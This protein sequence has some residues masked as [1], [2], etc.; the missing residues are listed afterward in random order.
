MSAITFFYFHGT[1][2]VNMLP[3][4]LSYGVHILILFFLLLDDIKINCL[5][6][7]KYI[8]WTFAGEMFPELINSVEMLGGKY[9]VLYVSDP[10][11]PIQLPYHQELERF[12]AEGAG[13][14]ASLNS[15]H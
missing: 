14:N 4:L 3:G 12:F 7:V 13:G 8:N 11:R 5:F 15:T 6:K 10:F 9:A 2:L 1:D